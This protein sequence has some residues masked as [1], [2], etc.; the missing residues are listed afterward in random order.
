[1]GILKQ[2]P[3]E[4]HYLLQA[5]I[6]NCIKAKRCGLSLAFK[7]S[8]ASQNDLENFFINPPKLDYEIVYVEKYWYLTRRCYNCHKDDSHAAKD[9]KV[10]QIC[11]H[12]AQTGHGHTKESPCTNSLYCVSCQSRKHS[13]YSFSCPKNRKQIESQQIR[14]DGN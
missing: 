12:C 4:F 3:F 14:R 10:P 11:G 8:F 7:L 13:C 9:C 2:V 1:M 6:P 5:L